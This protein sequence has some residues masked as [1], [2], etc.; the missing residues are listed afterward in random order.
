MQEYNKHDKEPSKY[1]KQWRGIK[2]KT[3]APY[4][5]DIGYER[6]L[7]PEVCLTFSPEEVALAYH[8]VLNESHYVVQILAV[9]CML[10]QLVLICSIVFQVFFNPEIYSNDF[11]TPLPAVI[12]KCIQSAP[13][14]TRRALYKVIILG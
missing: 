13:I 8:I 10:L 1:I 9:Y 14:D 5:C 6:F 7:G 2:P 11:T 4:S 3:G 12:D